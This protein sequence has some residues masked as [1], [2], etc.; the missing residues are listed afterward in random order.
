MPFHNP[1][2]LPNPG[3][4][5]L[6]LGSPALAGRFFT[7]EPPGKPSLALQ[8]SSALPFLW[9]LWHLPVPYYTL[10]L[11]DSPGDS[12]AEECMGGQGPLDSVLRTC[13]AYHN[14]C[15]KR[16]KLSRGLF[17]SFTECGSPGCIFITDNTCSPGLSCLL[18]ILL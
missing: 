4:E 2:N 10:V 3:I 12:L 9:I 15:W 16:S 11:T 5:L 17:G 6:S 14:I 18:H 7:T 13:P 1:K 8:L